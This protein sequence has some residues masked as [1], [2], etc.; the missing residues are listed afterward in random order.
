MIWF[1]WVV[2]Q[3]VMYVF[4]IQLLLKQQIQQKIYEL[5]PDSHQAKQGTPTM[6]GVFIAMAFF[7]GLAIFQRWSP[8]IVW[9]GVVAG[10]FFLIGFFDD[11]ISMKKKVNKGF[12]AR[13]KF[14]VQIACAVVSVIGLNFWVQPVSFFEF[15]LYVFLLTGT[16]NATNLTDGLDGLLSSTMI[17][18]LFGCLYFFAQQLRYDE[19]YIV[20]IMIGAL[21][22]FLLFNWSPAKVF[23]GD[24]GSLMLGAFLAAICIV[25]N[26]WFLLIGFGAIYII[27]TLSVMIQVLVYKRTKTR[28]FLMTPLHHHFELLGFGDKSVVFIFTGIQTMFVLLQVLL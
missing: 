12:T 28:V 16:S 20:C 11:I 4:G 21:F 9:V 19:Y 22:V 10:M 5:S 3:V 25:T 14:I 7:S 2:F 15:L 18:S 24:T 27:E 23:M 8:A 1:G 13:S 26:S 6:G 17:I